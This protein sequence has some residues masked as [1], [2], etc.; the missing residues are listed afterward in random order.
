MSNLISLLCTVYIC[1]CQHD[2]PCLGAPS[3]FFRHPVLRINW[4]I[5]TVPG[6]A[7]SLAGMQWRYP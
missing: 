1:L 3:E 2:I 6:V 7:G 5:Q 4:A